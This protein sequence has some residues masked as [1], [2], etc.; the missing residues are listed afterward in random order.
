MKHSQVLCLVPGAP[1]Y[2]PEM[3]Y[4]RSHLVDPDGGVYHVC[5]RCVRRAFLCGQD[6]TTGRNFDH[7]RQWIED[8]LLQLNDIFAVD[9]YA[10]AVMS[11]HYHIVLRVIPDRVAQW[12]DEDIA[13]RWCLLNTRKR[14]T[15]ECLNQRRCTLMMNK[16]RIR[17]IRKRL[18]S[19]SWLMRYL[20]EPI[21]RKANREDGCKGRFWEGRF[22][23]QRLLDDP[24]VIGAMV[25][26]DL[27]PVR[28]KVVSHPAAAMFTSLSHRL[29]RHSRDSAMI[30]LNRTDGQLP[31][32]GTL[33][34]YVDLLEWTLRCQSGYS[35]E[36]DIKG[37][38]PPDVWLHHFLP[39][40]G[41]WRR[42]MGS[43][44]SIKNY[45]KALGQQWIHSGI[46]V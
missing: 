25:Y 32:G 16:Q 46:P 1:G 39:K 8:R 37:V 23:S 18:Q 20:N 33:A 21:A 28:A 9:V 40:P 34:E 11:N 24:A 14:E 36:S 13:H 19:L 4:P 7:R 15:A 38:P 31:F 42:A 12:T 17:T 22:R 26:V 45:A 5:S 6:R 30:A 35:R 2:P 44:D 27:N 43:I 10:Y 3:T 41:Y 29:A